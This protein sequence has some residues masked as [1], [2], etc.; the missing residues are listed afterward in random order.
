MDVSRSRIPFRDGIVLT[1]ERR[2]CWSITAAL[3]KVHFRK[4]PEFD[5]STGLHSKKSKLKKENLSFYK[6]L[7]IS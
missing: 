6:G 1:V 4:G 3:H 5:A 7:M 2:I